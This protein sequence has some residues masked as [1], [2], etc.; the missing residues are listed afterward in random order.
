MDLD[1]YLGT[2]PPPPPPNVPPLKEIASG[3]MRQRMEVHRANAACAA[4]HKVM[5]PIGFS[6][7]NFDAIGAW[8]TT[9]GGATIDASAQLADGTKINGPSRCLQS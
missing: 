9:D 7:E 3:T 6:L 2:P 8:R 5:D 1:Q 4:C